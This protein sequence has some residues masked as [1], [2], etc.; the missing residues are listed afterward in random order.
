MAGAQAA[1]A[2]GAGCNQ[3]EA[4]VAPD[5]LRLPECLGT[6][7]FRFP[8]LGFPF[9]QKSPEPRP[10]VANQ[11]RAPNLHGSRPRL[12]PPTVLVVDAAACVRLG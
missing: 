9:S 1:L 6:R 5:E 3:P 4:E 2:R 11:D 10:L 8:S 12:L 7:R